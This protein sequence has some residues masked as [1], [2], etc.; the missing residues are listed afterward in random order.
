MIV[1]CVENFLLNPTLP[2]VYSMH[3]NNIPDVIRHGQK[4]VF[5]ALG[6]PLI[7][8]NANK[9]P[10]GVWM[11]EVIDRH[12]SDAVIVFSDIDAFPIHA[13][14][15]ARAVAC[16]EEG[17]I[18]GL[19]Q[20]S[21]H[22]KNLD[23][24]AGPMFMAFRKS[25]WERLGRPQLRSS[26]DNDAAEVMSVLARKKD[27]ALELVYP[28]SCLIPKWALAEHGVFGIGTFYGQCDFFHLFESRR[29]A[30]ERLFESV[31]SDVAAKR[32]LNF[33]EY[34]CIADSAKTDRPE[35]LKKPG[36]RL[37]LKSLLTRK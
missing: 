35:D 5:D 9:K 22:K 23:I 21:N 20:F 4:S 14:A 12:E 1:A 33:R 17:G 29:P 34:L 30:Y 7:H 2:P 36:F 19:A 27:V 26:S 15:Y 24:Y 8:E 11:N 16:A 31:V 25:T 37:R 3:W 6:I 32:K 13:E 10:H 28:S 18:F